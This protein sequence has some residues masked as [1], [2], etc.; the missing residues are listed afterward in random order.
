M[1]RAIISTELYSI[2]T[3][4]VPTAAMTEESLTQEVG[5][6]TTI[7]NLLNSILGAGVLLTSNSFTFAGLVPSLLVMTLVAVLSYASAAMVVRMQYATEAESLSRLAEMT[8]GKIGSGILGVSSVIF[9][10]SCMIAY[11]IMGGE[12]L[13]S[14]LSL[15]GIN[16][17]GYWERA[18]LVL[19]FS[20]I[21]VS[22]TIPRDLKILGTISTFAI[23]ALGFYFVAMIIKGVQILP[24][25]GISPSVETGVMGLGI[26]NA[27][28]IYSLSFALAVVIVPLISRAPQNLRKRYFASGCAFFLSYLIVVVPGIIGYLIFGADTK[29]MILSSFEADDGLIIAV[30][31]GYFIVLICSYPV[32]G[33]TV[34]AAFSKWLYNDDNPSGLASKKRGVVLV[35]VNAIS[36]LIAA[37]VP[38]VR[39]VMGVGGALGGGLSNFVF[40]PLFWIRLWKK[41]LWKWDNVICMIY[42][43]VG[44]VTVAI[45][46]FQT[47][48][49]AVVLL[50]G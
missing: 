24:E 31:V 19:F 49:D 23:F 25:Q 21:P 16:I 50:S 43:A 5:T 41:S 17:N 38:N 45:A 8:T 18:L 46:T 3:S 34:Q 1:E 7:M 20:M 12:V 32:L 37:L 15:A 28:S 14:W 9:C 36:V 13:V 42:V 26:F 10:Y 33:L 44:V 6:V 47:V 40:P 29:E 22:M 39:P 2:D 27:V 30:Q 35:I 11:V 4:G 48:K